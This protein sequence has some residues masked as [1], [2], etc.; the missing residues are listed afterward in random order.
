MIRFGTSLPRIAIHHAMILGLLSGH[1]GPEPVVF[2]CAF[3]LR[4]TRSGQSAAKFAVMHNTARTAM[5][6]SVEPGQG[7]EKSV[8]VYTNPS[9]ADHK[10]Q[11]DKAQLVEYRWAENQID[12]LP[13]LAVMTDGR[14]EIAGCTR[15][16]DGCVADRGARAAAGRRALCGDPL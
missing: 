4:L 7:N 2:C 6:R 15:R 3:G 8:G 9:A 11:F 16:C 12:R 13:G 10:T 1:S 14:R 5:M